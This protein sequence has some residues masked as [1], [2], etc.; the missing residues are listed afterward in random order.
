MFPELAEIV[1]NHANPEALIAAL[2]L[3]SLVG[4]LIVGGI[5]YAVMSYFVED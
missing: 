1:I 2:G 5:V 4:A 3:A